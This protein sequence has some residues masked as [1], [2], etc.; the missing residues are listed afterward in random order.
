MGKKKGLKIQTSELIEK[1][2][3]ELKEL[4]TTFFP[5]NLQDN[6]SIVEMDEMWT[7]TGKKEDK[8]WIWLAICRTTKLI[9]GFVTGTRGY[10]TGIKLWQK[11]SKL[12]TTETIFGTDDWNPYKKF[13]PTNQ[14]YIGK[15]ETWTIE[16]YNTNFRDDLQRLTRRTRAYSKSKDML[17]ASLALYI[18]QHNL[19][20]L[21]WLKGIKGF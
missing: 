20:K 5:T 16:G 14:H 17:D 19:T 7:Y 18:Y 11:I 13:I 1:Q 6:C 4:D 12:T 10:K 9:L 3:L 21:A 2:I 15:D 8:C